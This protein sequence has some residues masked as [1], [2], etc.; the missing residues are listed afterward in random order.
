[1]I[2]K[3]DLSAALLACD[4]APGEDIRQMVGRVL[5]QD[6]ARVRFLARATVVLWVLAAAGVLL[7]VWCFLHYL[8]PKLWVHAHAQNTEGARSVAGYWVMI[9][10]VT[11]WV[12][13]ALAAIVLFAAVTTVWL[14]FSSRRATLR[15]V[16]VQLTEISRQLRDLQ[17]SLGKPQQGGTA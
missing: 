16:N 15:Q 1:M 6:Q 17:A 9:S 7:M 10:G 4:S 2:N 8:E 14:I 13:G 12:V 3:N 11:A 5:E